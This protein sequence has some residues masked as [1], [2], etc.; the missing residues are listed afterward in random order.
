VA[1]SWFSFSSGW[2]PSGFAPFEKAVVE[3]GIS[4]RRMMVD[5]KKD[6]NNATELSHPLT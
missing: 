1:P 4:M 6:T 5:D 3:Y 2:V